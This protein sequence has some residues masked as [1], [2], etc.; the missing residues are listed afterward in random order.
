VSM[1]RG[2]G[3]HVADVQVQ[4]PP[5]EHYEEVA[6]GMQAPPDMGPVHDVG[7]NWRGE[8]EFKGKRSR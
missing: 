1:T 3:A 6:G 5:I 7:P 8:M 4:P 2:G